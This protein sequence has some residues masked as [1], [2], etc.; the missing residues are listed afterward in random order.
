MKTLRMDV[1]HRDEFGETWL[2][3]IVQR[4]DPTA[5]LYV[6]KGYAIVIDDI[7]PAR[8]EPADET[9]IETA[10]SE[11]PDHETAELNVGLTTNSLKPRGRPRTRVP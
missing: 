1:C 9:K 4:P 6:A 10:E 2:G 8:A 5:E 3:Q 7:A 11:M